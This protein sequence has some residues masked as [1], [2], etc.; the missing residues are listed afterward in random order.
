MVEYFMTEFTESEVCRDIN[1]EEADAMALLYSF[2]V[3]DTYSW[4]SKF[5][6]NLKSA[7]YLECKRKILWRI[8]SV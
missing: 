4:N 1:E 8:K 5:R 3:T 6:D 7:V 2:Y